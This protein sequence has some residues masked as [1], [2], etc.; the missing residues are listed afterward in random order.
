[1][2]KIKKITFVLGT[3]PQIIKSG[4][5]IKELAKKKFIVDIIHTGQH[6]D[7]NLSNIFLKN[8]KAINIKNLNI[9]AGTQLEQ[10]SKI[11]TK[12]EKLFKKNKP[13]LIVIPGDTTSAVAGA[14]SASKCK[15][16]IAH[17]EA[18]AR[19]N[20]F[21]M[22]EEINRRIIDHCS[23][24]LFAPT[25]NCLENLK[26]E[27]VFGQTYFVG[28][29][30][31]DQF[32]NWKKNTKITK[33]N[34]KTNEILIT[35]HRAENINNVENLKK[36]CEIVNKLQKK[37]HIIFPVHPNTKKQLLKNKLKINA[38]IILPQNHS[39]MMK[40]VNNADLV[41]T[42]SGGLQK[43]A[44]W[45]GTPCITIRENTE[46]K[47]TIEERANIIMPLSK[48]FQYKKAEKMMSLKFKTKPSLFGGGK[49]VDKII[50]VLKNL[51]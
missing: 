3:R 6:Y 41:I 35:I 4:P 20:Q 14:L 21:Y 18:G 16:K 33:N 51:E 9:G 11:I 30:M 10:I 45:M 7:Y 40:L 42:D 48:P 26:L 44:Y 50:K 31:Y 49:A 15:I 43:E 17:L 39:N 27:S 2:T 19:S 8:S 24:I 1:M 22:T 47:E 23:D 13:D 25:R 38:E 5:I 46:W 12:L 34:K 28:D 32:L 37:Y 29:T 36:I